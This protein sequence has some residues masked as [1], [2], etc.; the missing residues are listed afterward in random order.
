MLSLSNHAISAV[1]AVKHFF[2]RLLKVSERGRS[3]EA[4]PSAP[5]V[6][7]EA[8]V[9]RIVVEFPKESAAPS[10]VKR[11]LKHAIVDTAVGRRHRG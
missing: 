4:S 5:S 2:T 3:I 11:L 10:L 8:D 7:P 1:S 9:S 6:C